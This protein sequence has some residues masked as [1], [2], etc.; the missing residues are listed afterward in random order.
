MK[1]LLNAVV[2]A[3]ALATVAGGAE[4]AKYK[5]V[6]V[7]GGGSIMGKVSAGTAKAET[8]SYTISKDP[9]IC[10]TGNR[11]LPVVRVNGD[12]VLDAVV[13]LVKVKEG[14]AFPAGLKKLTLNQKKC[15]FQPYLSV[16]ANE[17]LLEAV[18]SDSTLH[19]IHTYELIKKARRTVLNVSQPEAGSVVE[20][21]IKLRKGTA[22]KVECDAH[23]FMHA[24]VFVAK[25]PYF[26]VVNDKGEFEIKDVP[27]GK[28]KINVWH[29]TL[30]TQ[31]GKVEVKGG[32]AASVNFS[33]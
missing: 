22:M 19:N 11:D 13:Y 12:A 4:A 32:G 30:G 16:M 9:D 27:P 25:N 10:G 6:T 18:N 17:G 14:K 24:F 2:V 15:E 7:S 31:K 1:M 8:R 28:Y 29:G 5:E 3:G 26:A 20:K 33:Y 23:D 21:K